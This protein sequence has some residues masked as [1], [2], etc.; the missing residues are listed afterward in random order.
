MDWNKLQGVDAR[1]Q[2]PAL[3]QLMTAGDLQGVLQAFQDVS[4]RRR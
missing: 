4:T 3:Q 1:R 2:L